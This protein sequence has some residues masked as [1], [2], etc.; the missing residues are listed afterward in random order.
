MDGRLLTLPIGVQSFDILRQNGYL[1][2]DKT[3]KLLELVGAS[4]RCFLSRKSAPM[5]LKILWVQPLTGAN[6]YAYN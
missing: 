6:K 1:Y 2:V 4:A 3:A 5:L